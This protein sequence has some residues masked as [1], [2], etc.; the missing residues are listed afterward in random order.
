MDEKRRPD[1][2]F[3][4]DCDWP[5][6]RL[7]E[8]SHPRITSSGRTSF[9]LERFVLSAIFVVETVVLVAGPK[10]KERE[11]PQNLFVSPNKK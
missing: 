1:R 6:P 10:E 3:E 9:D 7:L 2:P 8:L 4:N 5:R 11:F